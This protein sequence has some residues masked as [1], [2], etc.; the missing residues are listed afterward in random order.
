MAHMSVRRALHLHKS[1]CTHIGH[2]LHMHASCRRYFMVVAS[3]HVIC[4][5]NIVVLI[6]KRLT[7]MYLHRGIFTLSNALHLLLAGL[8][9]RH[10]LLYFQEHL[11]ALTSQVEYHLWTLQGGNSLLHPAIMSLVPADPL[12]V[13]GIHVSHSPMLLPSR[14]QLTQPADFLRFEDSCVLRVS[15]ANRKG[16]VPRLAPGSSHYCLA[17]TRVV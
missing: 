8:R 9:T 12:A 7:V 14:D 17:G 15:E 2:D 16:P 1:W 4:G 6:S 11:I 13:D 10:C 3:E 5:N